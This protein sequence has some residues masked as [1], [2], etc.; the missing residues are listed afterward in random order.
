MLEAQASCIPVRALP[1]RISDA[2]FRF[3]NRNQFRN[4]LHFCWNWN[5]NQQNQ[6]GLE[7]ESRIEALES[8]SES[9]SGILKDVPIRVELG[10]FSWSRNRN[11][12]FIKCWNRNRNRD[13][14][15]IVHPQNNH[16]PLFIHLSIV[17]PSLSKIIHWMDQEI[18]PSRCCKVN[19]SLNDWILLPQCFTGWIGRFILCNSMGKRKNAQ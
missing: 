19:S 3:R 2:W 16:Y 7:W 4:Q 10:N 5:R 9:E 12:K 11:Q 13:V 18:S 15:R 14:P 8:E 1:L 6:I 17:N